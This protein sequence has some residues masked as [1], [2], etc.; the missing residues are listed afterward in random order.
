MSEID[1]SIL[2]LIDYFY[3]INN[4]S[5]QKLMNSIKESSAE[6]KKII[7][8]ALIKAYK[9]HET[10]LKVLLNEV[11]SINISIEEY[12]EN[13]SINDILKQID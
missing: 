1:L 2:N 6:N 9:K 4:S 3:K 8:S 13:L 11:N 12:K 10:N 5:K 7:F